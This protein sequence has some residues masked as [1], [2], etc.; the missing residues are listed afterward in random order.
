MEVWKRVKG[1]S[2]LYEVSNLGNVR[3]RET[4]VCKSFWINKD[5]YK[6]VSMRESGKSKERLVHRI[7]ADTFIENANNKPQV[8]HI[9][10]N[11]LNNTVKNLEWVTGDEN[12]RHAIQSGKMPH[13]SVIGVSKDTNE[14][15]VFDSVREA[16]AKTSEPASGIYSCLCG[17]QR[18]TLNY[19]WIYAN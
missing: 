10:C 6:M 18:G 5:G 4:K 16:V 9:D 7:V 2:N 19:H 17:K 14:R 15:I 13:R 1:Y 12:I 8:N 3:M 11:K